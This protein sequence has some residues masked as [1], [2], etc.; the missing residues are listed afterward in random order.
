MNDDILAR[1]WG[2]VALRGVVALLFGILTLF[3]PAI[4]LLVLVMLFGAYA[5]VD[6]IFTVIAAIVHRRGE[7]HWVA[8]IISGLVGIAIGI[9][10]FFMPGITALALL[11]LIAVW[12]IV[13]G[14]AQIVAAVRLRRVI[15][16]EWLLGLAGALSVLFGIFLVAAPGAGALAV[17]LWVGAYAIVMGIVLVALAFRLRGW[18]HEHHHPDAMPHPA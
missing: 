13:T 2:L 12:A 7:R 8:L 6:G 4:T 15:H 14:L 17:V 1:N 10:T 5:L 9:V 18:Q 3:N 16:G 11:F